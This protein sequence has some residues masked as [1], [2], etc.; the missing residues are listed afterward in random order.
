MEIYVLEKNDV[1]FYIGKSINSFHRFYKHKKTYG[2]NISLYI[3]DIIPDNE[4]K[5]WEK[6]YI[7]LYK[8]KYN[9]K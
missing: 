6:Y 3:L 7:S 2:V 8:R 4:W 1:P 9:S 5:F